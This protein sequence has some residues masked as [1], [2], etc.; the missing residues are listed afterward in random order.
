ML[1]T[2]NEATMTTRKPTLTL[3]PLIELSTEPLQLVPVT[4]EHKAPARPVSAYLAARA[5]IEGTQQLEMRP[6]RHVVVKSRR[7]P[8]VH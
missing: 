3:S 1:Y 7:R 2:T 4:V 6:A 8:R 5:A